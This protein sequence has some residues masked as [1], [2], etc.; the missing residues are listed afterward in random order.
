MTTSPLVVSRRN[1]NWAGAW[2]ASAFFLVVPQAVLKNSRKQGTAQ[3]AINFLIISRL[4]NSGRCR[5]QRPVEQQA[6]IRFPF[7]ASLT[8]SH[9]PFQMKAPQR[10]ARH[11][12]EEAFESVTSLCAGHPRSESWQL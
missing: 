2:T 4:S 12:P 9:D 8:P 5:C 10:Q 11:A 3:R 1:L 7:L 6:R